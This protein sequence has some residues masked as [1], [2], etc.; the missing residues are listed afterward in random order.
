MP[1][2]MFYLTRAGLP[3]APAVLSISFTLFVLFA[4]LL[5]FSC[6]RGIVTLSVSADIYSCL[7]EYELSA[8]DNYK[9]F[10]PCTLQAP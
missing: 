1:S 10:S 8:F 4:V 9:F 3:I 6:R 2:T 7:M 5:C